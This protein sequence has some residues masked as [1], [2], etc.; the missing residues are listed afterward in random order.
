M[1][2]ADKVQEW[3]DE[4]AWKDEQER[5]PETHQSRVSTCFTINNQR[6]DLWLETD[7]QK[8][9]IKLYLYAPF[10]ALPKKLTDCAVLFNRIN[11]THGIG[12]IHMMP[13]GRIRFRHI[14]DVENTEPS[15]QM[16]SN[17]LNSGAAVFQNWFEEITAVALSKTTAQ[18]IFDE[19]DQSDTT[20]P[21]TL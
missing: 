4:Q 11:A 20:V 17:M 3:L 5:D 16:I 8:D 9:W 19:L 15:I 2:L 21:D 10:K 12:A 7:E 18:E 1:R 13:D 6:Y 14:V